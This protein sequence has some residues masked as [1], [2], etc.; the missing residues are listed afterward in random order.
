MNTSEQI[1]SIL[2]T[3]GAKVLDQVQQAALTDSQ[4]LQHVLE[5]LTS[6]DDTYRYNC[7]QV[8][9]ALTKE[10]SAKLFS[11]WDRFVDMLESDNVYHC[12]IGLCL[13]AN[14]TAADIHGQFA[15][16][17]E[18]YFSFLD[19]DSL[20]PARYA[21]QNA[22]K[23]ARNEPKLQHRI[24]A[25]LLGIE[26]SHQK[27]KELLKADAIQAFDEYFAQSDEQ[28]KILAFVAAQTDSPSPK[29]QKAAK[30]FLKKWTR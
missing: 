9:L 8:M 11:E 22:G 25:K 2:H 15:A 16:I 26:N 27:Q 21:A 20:I 18:R 7:F 29:T 28:E 24:T 6:Q 10:Q 3:R 13:L 1:D 14:L 12:N 30:T 23:I 4:I 5:G 17:L 19:G